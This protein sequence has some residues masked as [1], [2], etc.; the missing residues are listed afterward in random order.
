PLLKRLEKQG[1]LTRRRRPEDERTLEIAPSEDG[2]ALR[3]KA[4]E[5]QRGVELATGLS[6]HELAALR[7][8]LTDLDARLRT[9]TAVREGGVRPLGLQPMPDAASGS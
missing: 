1:L 7:E 6:G 4:R 2:L 3:E 9:A 8:Q 5:V